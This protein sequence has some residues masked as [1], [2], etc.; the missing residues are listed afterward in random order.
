MAMLSKQK[1][2]DLINKST[3]SKYGHIL[4]SINGL[5]NEVSLYNYIESPNLKMF[6]HH[7]SCVQWQIN[8]HVTM[9]PKQYIACM[10]HALIKY[11]V[12]PIGKTI[13]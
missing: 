13:T 2:H 6:D 10:T 12:G 1:I 9:K 11:N 5:S 8:S 3:L 7:K 4:G